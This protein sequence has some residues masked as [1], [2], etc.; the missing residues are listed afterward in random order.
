[1]Y[2]PIIK[3][4]FCAISNDEGHPIEDSTSHI[5]LDDEKIKLTSFDNQLAKFDF[6]DTF[7]SLENTLKE[8]YPLN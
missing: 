8:N 4:H 3:T 5:E 7:E 1:M 6:F 2:R